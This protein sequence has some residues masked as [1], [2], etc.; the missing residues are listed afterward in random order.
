MAA[1]SAGLGLDSQKIERNSVR[2]HIA[3]IASSGV[4]MRI[5]FFLAYKPTWAGDSPSYS[6]E[7]YFWAHHQFYLG[8]RTPVY[9][10]FLGFVQWVLRQ[11]ASILPSS[12]VAH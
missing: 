4:L 1:S 3:W 12:S 10:L 8:E 11:P 6:L 7:Y 5:F 2:R 9:P